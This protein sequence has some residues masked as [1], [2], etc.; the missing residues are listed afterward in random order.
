MAAG[1]GGD[2]PSIGTLTGAEVW[3][4]DPTTCVLIKSELQDR[5]SQRG[6]RGGALLVSQEPAGRKQEVDYFDGSGFAGEAGGGAAREEDADEELR[7]EAQ[8]KTLE[9]ARTG[10]HVTGVGDDA[11]FACSDEHVADAEEKED[12]DEGEVVAPKSRGKSIF[13]TFQVYMDWNFFA[14]GCGG[15]QPAPSLWRVQLNIELG[16]NFKSAMKK[17]WHMADILYGLVPACPVRHTSIH[18]LPSCPYGQWSK[19]QNVAHR[20]NNCCSPSDDE[21]EN[22]VPEDT[23]IVLKNVTN[24]ETR[25]KPP[26]LKVQ[27]IEKNKRITALEGTQTEGRRRSK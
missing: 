14:R 17:V 19:R 4:I 3:V 21:D 16:G 2:L 12:G 1:A 18:L 11:V 13:T 6:N 27:L 8:V 5:Q 22:L 23:Q 10:G 26:S 9:S 7:D 20:L 24:A 15:R 25:G